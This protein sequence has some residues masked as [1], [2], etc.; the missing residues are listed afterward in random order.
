M[1]ELAGLSNGTREW[2]SLFKRAHQELP[3]RSLKIPIVGTYTDVH[4]GSELVDYFVEHLMVE[5][6]R[7][8]AVEFLRQLTEDLLCLRLVGEIGNE[9]RDSQ[10]AQ[11]GPY[12]QLCADV[13]SSVDRILLSV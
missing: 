12:I 6:N 1:I 5:G 4:S 11:D 10:G 7:S 8:R 2:S 3:K 13:R 9:F